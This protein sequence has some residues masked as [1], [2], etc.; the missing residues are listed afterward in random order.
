ME[1]LYDGVVWI[2]SSQ[3]ISV[4]TASDLPVS[5][6][7]VVEQLVGR[8][9]APDEQVSIAVGPARLVRGLEERAAARHRLVAFLERRAAEIDDLPFEEA[10]KVIDEAVEFARHNHH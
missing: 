7:S 1:I 3:D 9:V 2:E 5:F 8:S 4:R 10:E 6:R